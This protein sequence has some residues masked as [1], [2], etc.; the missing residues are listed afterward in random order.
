MSEIR[1]KL[2]NELYKKKDDIE[3]VNG[4]IIF[5]KTEENWQVLLDIMEE[6]PEATTSQLILIDLGLGREVET[7]IGKL[8]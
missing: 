6:H 2:R 4:V 3:F 1:E 8:Q 5:A 7:N